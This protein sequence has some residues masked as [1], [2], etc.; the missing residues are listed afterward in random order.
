MDLCHRL[1]ER[2]SV[3]CVAER[4]ES[5]MD[6]TIELLEQAIQTRVYELYEK[7]YREMKE[8]SQKAEKERVE[9]INRILE[10]QPEK[11]KQMHFICAS[12]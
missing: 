12:I 10:Q 5:G 6:H 2:F 1:S 3:L 8:A 7:M 4:R 9:E 11:D